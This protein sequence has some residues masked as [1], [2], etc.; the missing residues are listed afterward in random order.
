MLKY[1]SEGKAH[2]LNSNKNL[3]EIQ[4]TLMY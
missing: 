1:E 4:L 2:S 3:H